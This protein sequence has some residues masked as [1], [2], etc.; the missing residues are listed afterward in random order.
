MK[1]KNAISTS[2]NGVII[3]IHVIPSSS[4]SIFPAGYNNWRRCI[5]VKV[6]AE[7]KENKAN[8]EVREKL[9]EYFNISPKGIS[10]ISGKKDRDKIILIKNVG[11]NK[12]CK[13]IEESLN[14]L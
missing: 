12:V 3:K 14:G 5:E 10:I 1:C 8:N 6:K 9:A 4:Q 7:A 13:R 2:E 11:I